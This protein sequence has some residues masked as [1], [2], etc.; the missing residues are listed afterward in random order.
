MNIVAQLLK[1]AVQQFGDEE[2]VSFRS[3]YSG[4][5]MYGRNCAALVG[6]EPACMEI[7]GHVIKRIHVEDDNIDFDDIVDTLLDPCRDNMGRASIV[8]YWPEVVG[9]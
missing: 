5:G 9:E 4:R 1:E 3:D 7:I 8:L 2:A 6:S